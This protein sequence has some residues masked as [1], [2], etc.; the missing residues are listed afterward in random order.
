[1]LSDVMEEV[2]DSTRRGI[3]VECK[4]TGTVGRPVVQ[5]PHSA[6]ATYDFAGPNRGMV[7]TT[8]RFTNLAQE[9]AA[10]LQQN[11]DPHPVELLDGENLREIA[12]EIGL[13]LYNGRIEIP[14]D[15]PFDPTT[16]GRC[17]RA[18]RG[19][20]R[21]IEAA[22]LPTPHSAGVRI[23][24]TASLLTFVFRDTS[25]P[26]VPLTDVRGTVAEAPEAGF[27]PASRP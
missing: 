5:K 10:R 11:D 12:D 26:D 9:Y 14:C 24:R 13:D 23:P 17:R 22:D 6:I 25:C 4:H 20:V 3:I 7:V 1:M 21:D 18:R 15:E 8:G 27:E 16:R 2:V 19:G